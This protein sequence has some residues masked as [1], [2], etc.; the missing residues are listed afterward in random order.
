MIYRW[1]N[2]YIDCSL[3]FKIE[4]ST[5]ARKNLKNIEIDTSRLYELF[6][7]N[8]QDTVCKSETNINIE[9][10][11]N[12]KIAHNFS[13]YITCSSVYLWIC[14]KKNHRKHVINHSS[15]AKPNG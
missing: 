7:V 15:T 12:A 8:E 2:L 5:W 13:E 3:F 10:M 14:S 6:C 1:E 11:L 9:I 4:K